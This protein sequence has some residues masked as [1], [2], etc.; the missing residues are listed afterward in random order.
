MGLFN[1]QKPVQIELGPKLF[2]AIVR[3]MEDPTGESNDRNIA[4]AGRNIKQ[5]L[6]IVGESNFQNSIALFKKGWSYGLLVPEQDNEIDKNAIALYL[7][8][9]KYEIHKV[10][11]LVKEMAS[12]VAKPIANLLIH[13]GQVVPVLAKVEG[14]TKEKPNL[15]VFAYARTQA[16]AF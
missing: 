10:G 2:K 4:Y 3:V 15:G 1:K 9:S 12:K 5:D 8:D 14:G 6:I 13:K 11:Y 7:I 16:V